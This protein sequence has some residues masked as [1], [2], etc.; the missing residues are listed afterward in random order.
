MDDKPLD[1]NSTATPIPLPEEAHVSHHT[2]DDNGSTA[3]AELI[4]HKVEALF[5]SHQDLTA[6]ELETAEAEADQPLSKH[7]QFIY[8]LTSS[9]VR[10]ADINAAWHEYYAGLNDEEKHQVWAE[11]NQAHAEASKLLKVHPELKEEI[12]PTVAPKPQNVGAK[13]AGAKARVVEEHA[14][15]LSRKVAA[16]TI[17]RIPAK[18]RRPLKSL[19]VGLSFGALVVFIFLFSFFNERLIAPLIQP[20]RNVNDIQVITDTHQPVST[21][22]EIIIPKINV[23]IPVIYFVKTT[24]EQAVENG[25]DNGVVHYADTAQPG[26]DG[27]LVIV[28]HSSSNIFNTGRYK[29][30]FSLLRR[31]GNGDIFYLQK[32]GVRYTYQ[33]YK[34]EVVRPTDVNVLGPQEKTATATLITCDPPGTSSNRLV[35]VGQQISPSVN[36]NQRKS[37]NNRD[38]TSETAIIPGNS[39]TLW[40]RLVH[41]FTK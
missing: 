11:F 21:K 3:A 5:D 36:S 13:K 14:K 40:S 12:Y 31:L 20:S 25:L 30:A 18:H 35:V 16:N 32:D 38:A 24:D 22:P 4:R 17:Y 10:P 26:Q 39:P 37:A 7:Q 28:G 6:G 2:Y 41:W 34:K 8:D 27:N 15:R 9:G 1:D 29:F 33:V 19:T 23:E